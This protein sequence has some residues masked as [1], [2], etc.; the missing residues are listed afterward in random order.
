[1]VNTSIT[2]QRDFKNFKWANQRNN[3][4]H[5]AYS[6]I[7]GK[8]AIMLFNYYTIRPEIDNRFRNWANTIVTIHRRIKILN[9]SGLDHYSNIRIFKSPNHSITFVD[10]FTIKR[11]GKIVD[12]D[13]KEIELNIFK[14]PSLKDNSQNV[15][16]FSIPGVE[17]GDEIEIEIEI[18]FQ[19]KYEY[20]I[21]S[22]DVFFNSYLPIINSVVTLDIPEGIGFKMLAYND[23]DK[24]EVIKGGHH[25]TYQWRIKNQYPS[26]YQ[27]EAIPA[28]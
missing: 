1:L 28:F 2:A 16:N 25:T 11:D 10:A 20:L 14:D 7:E 24:A 12:L 13:A 26:I 17:V 3:L 4:T 9:Q 5:L 6:I 22:R 23:L 21:S 27:D 8:D 18:I 15:L 19:F